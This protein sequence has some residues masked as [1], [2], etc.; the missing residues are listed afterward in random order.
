MAIPS[1]HAGK[2]LARLIEQVTTSHTP[3]EITGSTGNAV[4]IS[5][6][7]WEAIQETLYLSKIPGMQESLREGLATPLQDCSDSP[8]W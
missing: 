6:A 8:G 1:E 4:L 2:E 3:I 5:V 7:D